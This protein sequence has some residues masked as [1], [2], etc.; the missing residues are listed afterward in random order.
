MDKVKKQDFSAYLDDARAWETG[1][2]LALRKSARTAWRVAAAAVA[3]G[4][5]GIGAAT[6]QSSHEAPMPV[7]LRVD[8][9]TG[10]VDRVDS[11]AEGKITTSEA[12]DKYFA[13]LYVQ[14]RESW[15]EQ[16]ARDH[17]YRAALM[18]TAA[19]QQKYEA[20]YRRS[21]QSPMKVYGEHAKV[22]IDIKGTSF[23]QP[24]VASVRYV[25][26]VER[27]TGTELSHHTAT[28]SFAYSSGRMSEKDRAINPLGFQA[29]YR[30]DPD[31]PGLDP[32]ITLRAPAR[33]QPVMATTTPP[34]PA[35]PLDLQPLQSGGQ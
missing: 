7:V 18:S 29:E 20:F 1:A 34:A 10:I 22:R 32:V 17:Y 4:L 16:L 27:P 35:A 15:D 8:S 6:L 5:F 2:N 3:V 19:E 9:S 26:V 21:A 24:G 30:T 23:I 33:P 13:Q 12:T 25:R 31:T 28:V 11:L 14:Y